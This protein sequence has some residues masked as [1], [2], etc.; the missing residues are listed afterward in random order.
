MDDAD[1]D[2]LTRFRPRDLATRAAAMIGP[3]RRL[4]G[5]TGPPGAGKSTLATALIA[6]IGPTRAALVG[7]DGFHLADGE[8]ARLSRTERKGAPDTF[9]RAGF[10]AALRRLRE[11]QEVVYLPR[12]DR[13]LEAAIAGSQAVE[14]SIPL[15]VVEGNY[16][17]NWP[18]VA[19]LL[20][21]VWYLDPD[22][23]RR[24]ASLIERHVAFG[25]SRLAAREW[26][27]GS[28]EANAAL[29][30][31]DRDR[32]DLVVGWVA[33]ADDDDRLTATD[34]AGA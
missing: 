2:G 16:L 14:R 12:F 4:L 27:L 19:E 23:S 7:M 21:A 11:A 33:A 29:V 3:S 13:D 9:D 1:F 30:A 28:D 20:D 15:L 25:R 17:L 34:A 8:L 26:V 10:V 32:A 31:A 22:P 18:E 5:L 6:A 24:V